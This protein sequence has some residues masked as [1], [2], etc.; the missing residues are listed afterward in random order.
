MIQSTVVALSVLAGLGLGITAT[1][2]VSEY[3]ERAT[4]KSS[5]ASWDFRRWWPGWCASSRLD[6][7]RAHSFPAV[8]RS[9]NG[10]HHLRSVHYRECL[11]DGRACR[12]RSISQ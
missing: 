2:F 8:A 6:C 12:I 9:G 4:R 5:G 1:K 10:D 7:D 3:G 11:S